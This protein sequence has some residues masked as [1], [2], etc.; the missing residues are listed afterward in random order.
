MNNGTVM[1]MASSN[2]P[3]ER[4]R[5]IITLHSVCMFVL[6]ALGVIMQVD[7]YAYQIVGN[8]LQHQQRI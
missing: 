8:L 1:R 4:I 7:K 3:G 6:F 5:G 2:V